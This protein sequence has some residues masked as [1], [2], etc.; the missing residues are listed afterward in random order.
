M[1]MKI[2]YTALLLLFF[3]IILGLAPLS[4]VSAQTNAELQSQLDQ[5]NAQIKDIQSQ[6]NQLQAQINSNTFTIDGYNAQLTK[7]YGEAK[8]YT[9][10]INELQLQIQQL[11]T[12]ISIVNN[13]ISE[14]KDEIAKTQAVVDNLEDISQTRIEDSYVNFRMYGEG[15][16][17]TKALN[18]KNINA[19]FKDSQ[20]KE[21]IQSDTNK[22]LSTLADIKMDLENK[23]ADLDAQLLQL[24]K[25]QQEIQVK[26]T[27]LQQSKQDQDNKISE[28][29]V[30]LSNLQNKNSSIQ[31]KVYTFSQDETEKKAEANKIEQQ[32]LNNFIPAN[33]G[34]YVVADTQ[35]GK[36]G[37]TGLC[38]GAHLH[39]MVFINGA[40]RNPCGYLPA[41]VVG[42][43]GVSNSLL[44][45]WPM[46]GH[47]NFTSGFGNRCFWTGSYERCDFHPGIDLVQYYGAPIYT[48]ISGYVHKGVDG[49]GAKYIIVCQK[50]NCSGLKL[51]FWHLSA[52]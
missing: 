46:H 25:D 36:E 10:Q 39:F 32:I 7:L 24:Q 1:S 13:N 37:C 21:I 15:E 3:T 6:K 17:S 8:I 49:C 44:T 16:S 52:Y 28:Y 41:G 23:K 12:Q 20:Y 38:F 31:Y 18:M 9:D 29:M 50:P 22:D 48:P 30:S 35:I 34:Q 2:R 5:L 40:I 42:G 47:M 26:T 4:T 11:Q 45:M 27:D 51:G 19:Y 43:C 33:Q 14:K